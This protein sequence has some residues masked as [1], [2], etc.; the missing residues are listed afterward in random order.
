MPFGDTLTL[1][2]S[3]AVPTKNCL[4]SLP[5]ILS[6]EI[7]RQSI[8]RTSRLFCQ[9]G[10]YPGGRGT[11]AP[12]TIYDSR[13]HAELPPRLSCRQPR[14]CAEALY[15]GAVAALPDAERQTVLVHRYPCRGG[16]LCPG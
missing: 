5:I 2:S 6:P 1:P 4:Y 16:L 10:H 8:Y 3:A 13:T 11:I 9:M 7:T 15:R 12:C 14:R